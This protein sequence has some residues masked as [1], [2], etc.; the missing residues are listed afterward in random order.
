M[1]TD[2][3]AATPSMPTAGSVMRAHDPNDPGVPIADELTI[4]KHR[5]RWFR[6]KR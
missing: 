4:G 6:F 3:L 1:I 5:H 2:I